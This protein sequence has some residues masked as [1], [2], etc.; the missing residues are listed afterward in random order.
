[1]CDMGV[2]KCT[3]KGEKFQ[4]LRG[5]IHSANR[6]SIR[7]KCPEQHLNQANCLNLIV[8][9]I[10]VWNTVYMQAAV[11]HLRQNGQIISEEYLEHLA[12]VRY[13]HINIFGKYSFDRPSQLTD[14]G[15]R[16]L[17]IKS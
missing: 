1:M 12:P 2:A 14:E 9:A 6:G 7:K 16:P 3:T 17:L 10:A 13:E 8:N 15:L 5:Y 11:Q 4:A